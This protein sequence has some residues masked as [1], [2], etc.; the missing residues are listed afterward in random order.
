MFQ[1]RANAANVRSWK[2]FAEK[3]KGIAIDEVDGTVRMTPY[4]SLGSKDGFKELID[5]RTE[6]SDLN[7]AVAQLL[8]QFQG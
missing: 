3:A 1:P 5:E 4:V 2:S 6:V 8:R 7:G